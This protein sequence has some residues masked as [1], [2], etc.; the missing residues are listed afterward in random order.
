MSLEGKYIYCIIEEGERR[1]FGPIGL[2]VLN[3][4]TGIGGRGDELYTIHYRDIAAVVS[5]SPIRRYPVSRE[6]SMAHEHAI[7]AVMEKGYTVLPVRFSTIAEDGE[8]IKKVLKSRYAEFK[9]LLKK[10][11]N[12]VELGVKAIFHEE[13]IYRDI[14]DEYEQIRR[15]KEEITSRPPEKTYYQRI[16][17]GRMVEMALEEQ[18]ARYREEILDTLK[19]YCHDFRLTN[20]LIGERMIMNAAFLVDRD[21]EE[22]FDRAVEEL[23]EK[24]GEKVKLKYVGNIP[25]FNFVNI[26]IHLPISPPLGGGGGLPLTRSNATGSGGGG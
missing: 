7:E 16:E 13:V 8:R 3:T 18:K 20:R 10:M 25:P 22:K 1:N 11:R 15:L 17:I 2:P 9:D 12:K 4:H 23:A 21:Q 19:K 5:D 14:L 26:I 24:Y 6:N